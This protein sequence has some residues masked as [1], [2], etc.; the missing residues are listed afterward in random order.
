MNDAPQTSEIVK[1]HCNRCG[2][3]RKSFV[4]ADYTKHGS[5][6]HAAVDWWDTYQVLECCGCGEVIFRHEHRFSEDTDHEQDPAT[7][8][9]HEVMNVRTMYFPPALVRPLPKWFGD[10][11]TRDG[12]LAELLH[13]TYAALQNDLLVVATAGT[14]ILLDR[15]MVLLLG[16]DA[17]GFA[18]K[19]KSMTDKG[20]IG[21]ED[22]AL[23][24]AM[25]D[26]GHAASH[27]GYRP[28]REHLETILDTIE[29]LLHR[30]FILPSA[31][32][33][34]KVATPTRAQRR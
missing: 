19:L 27:R 26:A 13:E 16:E 8:E 25:I 10:L 12:L 29:N 21:A 18:D 15:V 24:G 14:R 22:R 2:D 30:K 17:G 32:T 6:G 31:V 28:P 33:E 34:M 11:E 1:A 3:P 9:W 5:D 7:G 20:T 23:L 4:K